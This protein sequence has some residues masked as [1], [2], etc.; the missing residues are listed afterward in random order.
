MKP[1]SQLR[2]TENG[3]CLRAVIASLLDFD[4][5]EVPDFTAAPDDETSKF[6]VWYIELQHWLRKQGLFF[7]EMRIR[8]KI[9]LSTIGEKEQ[10]SKEVFSPWNP[11]PWPALAMFAGP[12]HSGNHHIVIGTC[13]DDGFIVQFDPLGKNLNRLADIHSLCF[14]VPIDPASFV[15]MGRSLERIEKLTYAMPDNPVRDSVIAETREAR[16]L[17]IIEEGGIITRING[18]KHG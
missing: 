17:P 15:R 4:I 14:I 2:K 1:Q 9:P 5:N 11:L 8:G 7:L 16:G 10:E 6:P 13:E 12:T 18:H 3:D